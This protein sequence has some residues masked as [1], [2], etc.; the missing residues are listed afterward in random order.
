MTVTTE[1]LAALMNA[2][3]EDVCSRIDALT[4]QVK[5]TNGRLRTAETK[6]AVQQSELEAAQD[7]IAVLKQRQPMPSGPTPAV[8]SMSSGDLSLTVKRVGMGL[9][10]AGAA[11]WGLVEGLWRIGDWLHKVGVR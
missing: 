8:S 5:E 2:H 4:T 6:V 3:H 1:T 9:A 11:V 7:E 10:I